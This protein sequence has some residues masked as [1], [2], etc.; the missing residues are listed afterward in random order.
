MPLLPLPL[1]LP[2]PAN[3]AEEALTTSVLFQITWAPRSDWAPHASK[4]AKKDAVGKRSYPLSARSRAS[5][6]TASEWDV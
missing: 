6:W 2:L 5:A 3:A 4:Q 1:P